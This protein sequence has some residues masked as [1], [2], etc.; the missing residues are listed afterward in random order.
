MPRRAPPIPPAVVRGIAGLA[1]VQ[2]RLDVALGVLI[3]FHCMLCTLVIQWCWTSVSPRQD[4]QSASVF[5]SWMRV[6][7]AFGVYVSMQF[8]EILFAPAFFLQ[9]RRR[10]IHL[11][12]PEARWCYTFFPCDWKSQ[13]DAWTWQ[14]VVRLLWPDVRHRR[15]VGFGPW[16]DQACHRSSV[17]NGRR[18]AARWGCVGEC[19][20]WPR[21]VSE[22]GVAPARGPRD[23]RRKNRILE[24]NGRQNQIMCEQSAVSSSDIIIFIFIITTRFI[25]MFLRF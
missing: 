10:S 21:N 8:P 1:W 18:G 17:E 23:L 4:H 13:R 25:I 20:L 14:V 16:Q 5:L 11:A 3:G 12:F 7:K 24:T 6:Y 15:A 19:R 9:F 2:G 22:A